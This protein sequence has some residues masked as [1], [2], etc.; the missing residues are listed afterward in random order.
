M[1][2]TKRKNHN[3]TRHFQGIIREQQKEITRL[4]RQLRYFE[5]RDHL[6]ELPEP[7]ETPEPIL[8]T[9]M[10]YK[11]TNPELPNCDGTYN[12]LV[13]GEKVYGTCSECSHNKRLKK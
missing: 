6:N 7:E 12:E 4:K 10:K 1:A 13:I 11:C 9:E 5:K 3:E 2:K 8:V